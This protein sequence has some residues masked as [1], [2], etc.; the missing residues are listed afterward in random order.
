MAFNRREQI[1]LLANLT[2]PATFGQIVERSKVPLAHKIKVLA[3]YNAGGERAELVA[4]ITAE[5]TTENHRSRPA[6][7]DG[8]TG[9][10]AADLAALAGAATDGAGRQSPGRTRR[11][12]TKA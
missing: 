9:D 5:D 3:A 11:A 2:N 10:G 6:A 4:L 7:L 8:P 12:S 1:A